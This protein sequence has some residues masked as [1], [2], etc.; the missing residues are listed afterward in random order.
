[1]NEK[2]EIN[3]NKSN[4]YVRL[5][6]LVPWIFG[7]LFTYGYV[8]FAHDYATWTIWHK[9]GEA[10]LSFFLYPFILG[11]K[12]SGRPGIFSG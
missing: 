11:W 5:S 2:I 9:I 8:G 4:V 10:I 1:M 3:Q 12:F 7:W 6:W